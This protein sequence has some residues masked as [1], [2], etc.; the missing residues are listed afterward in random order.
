MTA[1]ACIEY[2]HHHST[3]VI[4]RNRSACSPAQHVLVPP[5]YKHS[6]T[7]RH[8]V[9]LDKS[10]QSFYVSTLQSV[11][12]VPGNLINACVCV[13]VGVYNGVILC[14][15]NR[16]ARVSH[17]ITVI[18]TLARLEDVSTSR[19]WRKVCS[20]GLAS[21]ARVVASCLLRLCTR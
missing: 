3:I 1:H 6:C 12:D 14:V 20:L 15:R 9:C 16:T 5:V 7:E 10:A 18:F 21:R 4:F 17:Q 19:G 8:Y 2:H 11:S 13:D